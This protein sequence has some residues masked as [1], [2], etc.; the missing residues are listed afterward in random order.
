MGYKFVMSNALMI[1]FAALMLGSLGMADALDDDTVIGD[2]DKL[3]EEGV[4]ESESDVDFDTNRLRFDIEDEFEVTTGTVNAL[5]WDQTTNDRG[6]DYGYITY[7]V[8]GLQSFIVQAQTGRWSFTSQMEAEIRPEG[9]I[10]GTVQE[11]PVVNIFD[12]RNDLGNNFFTENTEEVEIRISGDPDSHALVDIINDDVGLDDFTEQ[13]SIE[14]RDFSVEESMFDRVSSAIRTSSSAIA[15]LPFLI[16]AWVSFSF[17]IPGLVG[18][19]FQMYIAALI[20]YLLVT[21]VW[22]G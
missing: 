15:Q 17:A 6:E 4:V 2:A 12:G 19:A 20:L 5:V 16:A 14:Q 8:E 7:D 10:A 22:I 18:T 3:V 1:I 13:D 11:D 9:E 21:E